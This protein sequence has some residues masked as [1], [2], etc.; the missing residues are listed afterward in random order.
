VGDPKLKSF[1]RFLL[2]ASIFFFCGVLGFA[3]K[4]V[5]SPVIKTLELMVI[6]G[7]FGYLMYRIDPKPS[8]RKTFFRPRDL[9]SLGVVFVGGLLANY[10]VKDKWEVVKLLQF[11]CLL[12]VSIFGFRIAERVKLIWLKTVI[13]TLAMS[14]IFIGFA[15]LMTPNINWI[16]VVTYSIMLPMMKL[17]DST[18]KDIPVSQAPEEDAWVKQG[19]AKF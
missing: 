9:L 3:T 2:P 12:V 10:V 11:A 8:A 4:G 1:F 13:S 17:G 16:F 19:I 6:V 15:Y 18:K 7:A 14:C 5:P